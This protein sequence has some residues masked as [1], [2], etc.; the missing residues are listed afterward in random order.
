MSLIEKIR[1]GKAEALNWG[2][3]LTDKEQAL[4]TGLLLGSM[5][6]IGLVYE[7]GMEP[8]DLAQSI[9][10]AGLIGIGGASVALLA[11]KVYLESTKYIKPQTIQDISTK[12]LA[13][14]IY[15]VPGIAKNLPNWLDHMSAERQADLTRELEGLVAKNKPRN[16]DSQDNELRL[17]ENSIFRM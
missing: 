15:A 14:S 6:L 1:A 4:N 16:Q 12:R 9:T 17:A 2:L 3:Q 7:Q 11:A 8:A 10:A 5:G 13:D